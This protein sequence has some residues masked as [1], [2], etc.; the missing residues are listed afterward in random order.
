MKILAVYPYVPWPLNRGAYHRA[1]HLLKGLAADHE[2]DLLALAENGESADAKHVFEEFCNR[3]EVL[4]FNHP[5]WE[6]LFPK[7]LLNPIPSTIAH[8]TIPALQKRLSEILAREHYDAVHVLDLVL[9]QFFLHSHPAIPLVLD[10]TRVDLQYQL[11]EAKRLSFSLKNRILNYENYA[12]LWAYEKR[13]A[14]RCALQVLCGP[15]DEDFVRK[16]ISKSVPL[17]IIPNG[18]DLEYF[19]PNSASDPRAQE[20]TAIFCGAM[21]YNPN[22]DALRWYF[23]EI[24]DA[25]RREIPDLRVL[26]VGKDP[27]AE[28]KAYASKPGVTVTGGVP[29]V[30]PY[31]K[32]A[33]LQIVPLRIGGGTRLKIVESL[34]IKTPVVSTTIGAQGLDLKHN[35]DILYADNAQDF[36]AQTARAL[37]DESL[38]KKL[39]QNGRASAE[40]RL[41]WKKLGADLRAAYAQ[42]IKIPRVEKRKAAL[43][44]E[45]QLA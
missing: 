25:L 44:G 15:D 23:A 22:V 32:R 12:K 35:F 16:Y 40:A 20:P 27:I 4:P 7:R 24:H 17:S 9:T 14:K 34:G 45:P 18:V 10:R 19:H 1:F 6:R 28:V 41:S 43:A 13:V 37:R 29:D 21:D 33:W 5:E 11:M 30:R 39:E 38:R 42:H 26:I 2:V 36:V 31:Y 8:W 3:V